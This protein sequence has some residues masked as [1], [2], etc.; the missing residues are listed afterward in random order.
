VL[1][2]GT[3]YLWQDKLCCFSLTF[4][5]SVVMV[6]TK[7]AIG[8]SFIIV[9]CLAFGLSEYLVRKTVDPAGF[10]IGAPFRLVT[11]TGQPADERIFAGTQ[12]ALFFGFTH[13]PDI[14]PTTLS[15]LTLWRDQ[16]GADADDLQIVFVTVDPVRDTPEILTEY[17]GFF[18]GSII[19]LTGSEADIDKMLSD[20]GIY[21]KAFSTASGAISYDHTAT[22]FLLNSQGR[23]T[24]TIALQESDEIAIAKLN[25]LISA[26]AH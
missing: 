13:C 8:A 21:R 5:E 9:L 24:G 25:N 1:I 4:A 19:G 15:E 10:A 3:P 14:C 20:W 6:K 26:S 16:I 23:L 11:Q 17:L 12:T 2:F 18:D 22:I 7:L